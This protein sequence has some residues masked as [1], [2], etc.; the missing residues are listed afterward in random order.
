MQVI[1]S[2]CTGKPQVYP[3]PVGFF[4]DLKTRRAIAELTDRVETVERQLKALRL[5]WES[6]YDKMHRIAQ[7]VAKRAERAEADVDPG[8]V[9][10]AAVDSPTAN[11]L[12][13]GG[14]LSPRQRE[15]QQQILRQRAG[16]R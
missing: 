2:L 1:H 13:M 9:D 14:G 10:G 3:H 6:T 15:I 4:S 5:D 12:T 7:R 11:T 8:A 16:M